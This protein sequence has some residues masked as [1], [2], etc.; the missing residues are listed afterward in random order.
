MSV[1]EARRFASPPPSS[2]KHL[3]RRDWIDVEGDE[4]SHQRGAPEE[5]VGVLDAQWRQ[6]RQGRQ[7]LQ[8]GGG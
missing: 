7:W 1:N 3:R 8:E 4:A 6:L 2:V 5:R